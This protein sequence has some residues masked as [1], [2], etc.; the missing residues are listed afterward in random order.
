MV[1]GLE[2][3]GRGR[4]GWGGLRWCVL[5][6]KLVFLLVIIQSFPYK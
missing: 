2:M 3:E 1:R 4:E 5:T 6:I